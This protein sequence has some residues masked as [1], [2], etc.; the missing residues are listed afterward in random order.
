MQQGRPRGTATPDNDEC[1]VAIV[2]GAACSSGEAPGAAETKAVHA[3]DCEAAVVGGGGSV[4]KAPG[5]ADTGVVAMDESARQASDD[6]W[7]L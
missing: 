4:G 2:G 6:T 5:A 1:E 3:M 7:M